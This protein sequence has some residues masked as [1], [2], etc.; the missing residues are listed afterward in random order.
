MGK[1]L[2]DLEIKSVQSGAVKSREIENNLKFEKIF[3]K[4]S[5]I[6]SLSG[7]RVCVGRNFSSDWGDM[8]N[9]AFKF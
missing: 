4:M 5:D 1:M 3:L 9:L 2:D 8:C 7:F 6:S